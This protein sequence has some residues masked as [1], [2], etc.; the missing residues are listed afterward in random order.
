MQSNIGFG[1]RLENFGGARC[2]VLSSKNSLKGEIVETF[3]CE[4][5]LM[6]S[7]YGIGMKGQMQIM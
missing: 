1:V 4:S 7:F 3:F 6:I 2:A 5:K